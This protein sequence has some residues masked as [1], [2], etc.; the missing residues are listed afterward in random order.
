[1]LLAVDPGADAGWAHFDPEQRRLVACGLNEQFM[2]A[3]VA[4]V[5]IERP[6]IYPGGRQKARPADIIKLAT[7]AGEWGGLGRAFFGVEPEYVEPAKWKG[8]SVP[9]SIHHARIWAVL[10]VDEQTVV[11]KAAAGIAPSKRHNLMDAIGIGLYAVG[12]QA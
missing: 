12:R 6:M 3:H 4:R 7:R 9:K 8:G 10:S 2:T 5:V 1:M 11:S